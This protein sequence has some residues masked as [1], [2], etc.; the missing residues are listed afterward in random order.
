MICRLRCA[1][2]IVAA[3][4]LPV[5][6]CK[7]LLT[8][9]TPL[10]QSPAVEVL[11][12][13]VARREYARR[14]MTNLRWSLLGL[15]CLAVVLV[16]VIRLT[17]YGA[18]WQN[19]WLGTAVPGLALLCTLLLTRWPGPLE[20]ACLIDRSQGLRDLF[21]TYRQLDGSAGEYQPLVRASAEEAARNL[22]PQ[23]IR[24]WSVGTGWRKVFATSGVLLLAWWLLPQWDPFGRVAQ[25]K[26]IEVRQQRLSEFRVQTAAR[27]V[28]LQRRAEEREQNPA[29]E[30]QLDKLG[31]AFREMQP[32]QPAGNLK[33]LQAEQKDISA[34][35]RDLMARQLAELLK[36]KTEQ[37][38]GGPQDEVLRKMKKDLQ[39][40]NPQS[41]E[42]AIQ[43]AQDALQSLS[44]TK[45]PIEK[46][47]KKAELKKKLQQLERLANE[48]L[49][50]PELTE[51]IR[52][53]Q[54]QMDLA[55]QEGMSEQALSDAMESLELSKDELQ[56]LAEAVKDLKKLEQALKTLQLARKLNDQEQLDGGECQDCQSM[57]D[58]AKKFGQCLAKKGGKNGEGNQPGDGSGNGSGMGG[59]GM[60]EGGVAPEN[61]DLVTSTKTEQFKSTLQAGKTLLSLKTRGEGEVVPVAEDYQQLIRE[62]RQGA[63][64]A[65][66]TEE[67]PPGYVDGITQYFDQLP[68]AAPMDSEPASGTPEAGA[69]GAPSPDATQPAPTSE[70]PV[71]EPPVSEPAPAA[72]PVNTTP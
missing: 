22:Q 63:S 51:A 59:P 52:R 58:Y 57:A 24:P 5:V 32:K 12:R 69:T 20:T 7:G 1:R 47:Q 64:E 23:Q 34:A 65:I 15:A 4:P 10:D 62:V 45:D 37:G 25:A 40:G 71:S 72:E 13:A 36:K 66:A 44:K 48:E 43:Q 67:V 21:Q 61:N 3:T 16:C 33:R 55:G 46:E 42:Q 11:Q 31:Q 9:T 41:I 49:G 8:M 53:A 26:T 2:S 30:S 68:E 14:A 28:E 56:N 29:T 17:G 6:P 70:L 54:R 18:E 39:E 27:Q 19:P 38:L 60:G 35:R 50:S